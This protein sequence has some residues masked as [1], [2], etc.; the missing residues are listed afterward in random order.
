MVLGAL[1]PAGTASVIAPPAM[2]PAA[3]VYVKTSVWPIVLCTTEPVGVFKLPE[4]FAASTVNTGGV[5]IAVSAPAAFDFSL[6]IHVWL[7]VATEAVAPG[8]PPAFE[9]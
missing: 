4:P 3:T 7:P 1:Q 8:P 9:P 6:P 5:P 2:P